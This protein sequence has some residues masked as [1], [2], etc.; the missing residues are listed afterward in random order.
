MPLYPITGRKEDEYAN[1]KPFASCTVEFDADEQ[2]ELTKENLEVAKAIVNEAMEHAQSAA[3]TSVAA[4]S[5]EFRA[6]MR[7]KTGGNNSQGE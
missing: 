3:F 7:P 2:T 6:R 5:K 1:V 4:F